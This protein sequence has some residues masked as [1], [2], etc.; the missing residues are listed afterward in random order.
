MKHGH[1]RG[2]KREKPLTPREQRQALILTESIWSR[3][4]LEAP[5]HIVTPSQTTIEA[6]EA[7]WTECLGFNPFTHTE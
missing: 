2:T 3:L 1:C 4:D 6:R 7:M 5:G